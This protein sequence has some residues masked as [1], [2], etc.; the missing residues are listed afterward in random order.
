VI[1][2]I[3]FGRFSCHSASISASNAGLLEI[4]VVKVVQNI[5]CDGTE[6]TT[7]GWKM[8]YFGDGGSQRDGPWR[9]WKEMICM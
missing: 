5:D 4:D 9:T 6:R 7:I 1:Q 3:A 8:C 2:I